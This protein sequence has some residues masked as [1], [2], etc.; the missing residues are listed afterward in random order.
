MFIRIKKIKK[1]EYAYLVENKWRK[2]KVKD[3]SKASRQKVKKYLG[4]IHE[5]KKY[6]KNCDNLILEDFEGSF[7]SIIHK[8][9]KLHLINNGF[10]ETDI[11]VLEHEFENNNI[12]INL[13]EGKFIDYKSKSVVL[14]SGDGYLCEHSLKNLLEFKAE[15]YEEDV[16]IDLA[17]KFVSTGIP[18][19]NSVFIKAFE[20]VFR[21][22]FNDTEESIYNTTNR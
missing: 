4:R 17:K 5:L 15:G 9:V 22:K 7:K 14:K 16:G 19:S 20:K 18:I 6:D 3:R 11:N 21:I 8:L 2:Y 13:N 12:K 1:Y 10:K